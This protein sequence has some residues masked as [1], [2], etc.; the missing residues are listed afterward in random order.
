MIN[1]DMVVKSDIGENDIAIFMI[2]RDER[3]FKSGEDYARGM[4]KLG[5]EIVQ[6]VAVDDKKYALRLKV[7]KKIGRLFEKCMIRYIIAIADVLDEVNAV[8][9]K[10]TAELQRQTMKDYLEE[11]GNLLNKK[12]V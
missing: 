11:L 3:L 8:C 2:F 7:D 12:N 10:K 5:P 9:E 1:R 6:E 4:K